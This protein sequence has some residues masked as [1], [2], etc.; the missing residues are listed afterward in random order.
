MILTNYEPP[1]LLDLRDKTLDLNEPGI[2]VI[3]A[4]TQEHVASVLPDENGMY[5][6]HCGIVLASMMRQRREG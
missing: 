5:D 4:K 6:G 3:D 2:R 1:F